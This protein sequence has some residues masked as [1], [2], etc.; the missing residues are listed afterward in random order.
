[1]TVHRMPNDPMHRRRQPSREPYD[2]AAR[3]NTVW[4]T[5]NAKHCK[6]KDSTP[7]IPRSSLR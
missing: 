4:M 7:T 6:P 1:M 5:K 2:R 3:P